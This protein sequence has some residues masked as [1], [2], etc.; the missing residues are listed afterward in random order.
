[1]F[2]GIKK[3][4]GVSRKESGYWDSDFAEA[5]IGLNQIIEVAFD[6]DSEDKENIIIFR[7]ADNDLDIRF[8][9]ISD[10]M[11]EYQRIKRILDE[12]TMT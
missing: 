5:K 9:F 2:I 4:N 1:M 8:K 6:K 10:G 3:H 12:K 7:F 11:G